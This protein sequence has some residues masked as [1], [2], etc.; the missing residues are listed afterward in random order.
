MATDGEVGE[1]SIGPGLVVGLVIAVVIINERR[2]DL[3]FEAFT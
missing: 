3:Q 2:M 1:G